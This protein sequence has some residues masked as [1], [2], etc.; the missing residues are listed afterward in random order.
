MAEGGITRGRAGGA[1][2]EVQALTRPGPGNPSEG[3]D[4][5]ITVLASSFSRNTFFKCRLAR[6][7]CALELSGPSGLSEYGSDHALNAVLVLSVPLGFF[8]GLLR[9]KLELTAKREGV[10]GLSCALSELSQ[11]STFSSHF[12]INFPPKHL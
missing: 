5:F 2:G 1:S 7:K 4:G 10:L 12:C 9:S 8:V 3:F 11:T 6:P